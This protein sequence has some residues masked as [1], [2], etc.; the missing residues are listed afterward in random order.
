MP[1][2]YNRLEEA[3]IEMREGFKSSPD[4]LIP[5]DRPEILQL[6]FYPRRDFS[7][8]P[9]VPNAVN[10]FVPVG[11]GISI[12]CRFYFGGETSPTI[13]FFHGNGEIASDYDELAPLFTQIGINLFV[14]DYRGYGLSGGKP[15]LA[16]MIKDA[17]FIFNGLKQM[18]GQKGYCESLFVMGRSLG[19]ASAIELAYNYQDQIK[20]LIIESGFANIVRL[21]AYVGVPVEP[22]GLDQE[23]ASFNVERIRFIS[24]PTLIIH[25]ERDHLI[26]IRE[27]EELYHDSAAKDKRLL[28]IPQADHNSIF[29]V[30][31]R[32]YLQAMREFVT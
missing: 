12:S 31:M 26:P 15:T 11:E 8:E 17:H 10:H 2:Y 14:A 24:I 30:G 7:L 6:I 1:K 32:Q 20:G 23:K 9:R 18:L 13:L 28:T 27:G 25:G 4:E 29:L 19:S 21:L 16:D 22:L 5:L 3:S